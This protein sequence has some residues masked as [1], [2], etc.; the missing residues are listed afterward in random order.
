MVRLVGHAAIEAVEL[1]IATSTTIGVVRHASMNPLKGKGG[2][3]GPTNQLL[4]L[5]MPICQK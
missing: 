4:L 2:G 3:E 1:G 5:L